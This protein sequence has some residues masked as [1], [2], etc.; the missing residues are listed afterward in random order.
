M[1][2]G[3]PELL[4]GFDFL[5]AVIGLFGIGEIL[6]TMEEGLSFK[7]KSA[8]INFKVVW[9]TW[10]ELLRHWKLFLRSVAV[11]CWMGITPWRR[12]AGQLHELRHGAA[13]VEGPGQFRQG[14]HRRRGGARDRRPR[15]RHLGAAAHA[16]AGHPGFAHRGGAAGWPAD[17]GPAARAHAVRGAEGIC[18]GPDR[19]HVHRQHRGPDRGADHGA[20][21][22]GHPAHPV[23]D[24]RAGHHRHLRHWR[25]HRAQLAC[26]T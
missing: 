17:L 3:V 19:Q 24:H 15:R 10:G 6:L 20:L 4:K 22:G 21:V 12:H 13:H 18:L 16:D 2:F 7:G 11:G 14:P 26:S 8:K 1:T 23:F 5:I 25:L 9:Q